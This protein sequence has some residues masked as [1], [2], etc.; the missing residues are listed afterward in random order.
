[1]TELA[2]FWL[3]VRLVASL[4]SLLAKPRMVTS[5]SVYTFSTLLAKF[6]REVF[7]AACS[8]ALPC[9]KRMPLSKVTLTASRPF[10]SF[11]IVTCAFSTAWAAALARSIFLPMR[12]PAVPPAATPTPAPMAAPI[13]APCLPPAKAPIPAPIALPAAP[14]AAPPIIPPLAALLMPQLPSPM[15]TQSTAIIDL[16][17]F[18]MN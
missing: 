8:S 12:A 3:T 9:L 10:T 13:L 17:P 18:I 6:C 15:L 14:P 5:Q 7:A 4:P 11:T 1:M 2:R 16:I